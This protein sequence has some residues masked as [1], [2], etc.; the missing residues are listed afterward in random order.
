MNEAEFLER[1][2][3]E[4]GKTEKKILEFTEMA[5]PISP[6]D[7]IG[8]LSRMD[9]INNKS[10]AEAA[11]HKAKEKLKH[12]HFVKTKIGTA[13]FGLCNNCQNNIPL[14]RLIIRP[15]SIYCVAC[16]R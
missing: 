11:L 16:A 9:A 2:E 4:I 1:L 13:E 10:V 8:R 6:D 5:K 15:E 7:A 12:L 14:G 3:K